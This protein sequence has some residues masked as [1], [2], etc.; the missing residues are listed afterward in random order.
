MI[1]KIVRSLFLSAGLALFVVGSAKAT[2]PSIL[3]LPLPPVHVL[4]APIVPIPN[5]PRAVAP[6]FDPRLLIGSVAI[7]AGVLLLIGHRRKAA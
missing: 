1:V 3:P 5:P 6:E 4:P 7:L 2:G